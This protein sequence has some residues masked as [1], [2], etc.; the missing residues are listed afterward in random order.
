MEA[1]NGVLLGQ[2]DKEL[3]KELQDSV[4]P[5]REETPA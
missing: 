5:G 1:G 3:V 4:S 2:P